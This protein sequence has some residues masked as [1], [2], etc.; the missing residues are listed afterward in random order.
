M[1]Y[2][3]WA[4]YHKVNSDITQPI[5]VKDDGF[6]LT[7]GARLSRNEVSVRLS[8]PGAGLDEAILAR[9][10]TPHSYALQDYWGE[11]SLIL[12]R[13]AGT[14]FEETRMDDRRIRS[15]PLRDIK[16]PKVDFRLIAIGLNNSDI[17]DVGRQWRRP[18]D[19]S[20][21]RL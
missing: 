5:G 10:D 21:T 19:N 13:P 18:Y 15:V 7:K 16:P 14:Y 3:T 1:K 9:A 2:N 8:G 17:S 6:I 11:V 12:G 20:F 4:F